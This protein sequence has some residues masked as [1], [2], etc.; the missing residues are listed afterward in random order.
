MQ[1]WPWLK[2]SQPRNTF[3]LFHKTEAALLRMIPFSLV[4]SYFSGLILYHFQ[5]QRLNISCCSYIEQ[6]LVHT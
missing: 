5:E 2:L 3:N 4:V 1:I 6:F